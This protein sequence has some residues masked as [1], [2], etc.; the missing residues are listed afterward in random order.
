MG[1]QVAAG[2]MPTSAIGRMARG[3]TLLELVVV[4]AILAVLALP[5]ALSLGSVRDPGAGAAAH[6]AAQVA[7]ARDRA[8]VGGRSLVLTPRADG[9]D[10]SDG[11]GYKATDLAADWGGAGSVAFLPDRRGTPFA[12]TLGGAV[13]RFDGA[14][15]VRCGP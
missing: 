1:A 2:S 11:A 15:P 8:M 3:L 14:G 4:V 12:V 6:L 7:D 9:W 10:W 5:V 13:C